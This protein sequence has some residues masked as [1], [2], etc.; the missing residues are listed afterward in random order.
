MSPDDNRAPSATQIVEALRSAGWLLEQDTERTLRE[1]DF[2][3]VPSFAYPDIDDPTTSREVDVMAYKSVYEDT[4]TR[5][6]VGVRVLAECKQTENPYV[7]IGR[8]PSAAASRE[9]R[10]EHIFRFRTVE[11]GRENISADSYRLIQVP[12]HRYLG[13]DRLPVSPWKKDF[14]ANQMTRLERRGG[15]WRA[16]NDG[17]FNSLIY[18]LAKATTHF[19]KRHSGDGIH[20]VG[21]DYAHTEFIYPV[22]VT[23]APVYVLDMDSRPL[24]PREVGWASMARELRTNVLDARY[25]IDVV[26]YEHLQDWIRTQVLPFGEAVGAMAKADPVAF[27]RREDHAWIDPAAGPAT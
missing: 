22:V 21:Q 25:R 26:N 9:L 1:N 14:E 20:R 16:S 6:T 24:T 10:A 7:L 18:P 15:D 4:T 17:I 23:S 19:R 27:V 5:L 13:L 3:T 12:P 8:A 11:V 2:H